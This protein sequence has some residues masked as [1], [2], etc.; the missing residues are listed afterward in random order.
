MFSSLLPIVMTVT[1]LV[2]AVTG[3]VL[4]FAK[5]TRAF[6]QLCVEATKLLKAW[7]QFKQLSKKRK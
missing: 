2:I 3:L 5:L 7:Q 4:S 6:T 1:F